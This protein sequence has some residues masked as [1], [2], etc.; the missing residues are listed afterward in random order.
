MIEHNRELLLILY[1]RK[2]P[3]GR[4]I[5]SIPV[6][7]D[8]SPEELL[9]IVP[10]EAKK[11]KN[12]LLIMPDYVAGNETYPFATGKKSIA[13]AFIRRKLSE[14]FPSVPDA[15]DFYNYTYLKSGQSAGSIYA[16]YLH[17]PLVFSLYKNLQ[18][19]GLRPDR[20]S[21]PAYIWQYKINKLIDGASAENYCLIHLLPEESY[22]YFFVN[23]NYLF[24]RSIM[25][26]GS[27]EIDR[28]KLDV[29]AFEISQSLRLFSQK[30]KSEVNR[31]FFVSSTQIK[32]TGL[33]ERLG[34][35]IVRIETDRKEAFKTKEEDFLPAPLSAFSLSDI[36]QKMA[37]NISHRFVVTEKAWHSAIRTG[38]IT[39]VLLIILLGFEAFYLNYLSAGYSM[40]GMGALSNDMTTKSLLVGKYNDTLD[41]IQNEMQRPDT[42]SILGGIALSLP[43]SVGL[44]ELTLNLES[45]FQVVLKGQVRAEDPGVIKTALSSLAGGL[46]RNLKLSKPAV[47]GDVGVDM[48]QGGGGAGT[49]GYKFHIQLGLK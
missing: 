38:I 3:D 21:I 12:P 4:L 47:I 29:L 5:C 46:T 27:E 10:D 22:L 1:G 11:I 43:E 48:E 33:S 39:G 13:S 8:Y 20:I 16:F 15:A 36:D 32:E 44:Q 31:F 30:A 37:P 9:K 25:L 24:S 2:E 42:A 7:D 45:P 40:T 34:K 6:Q 23:G 19:A 49:G 18:N 14:S 26:P 35:N 41:L 28:G 17:D